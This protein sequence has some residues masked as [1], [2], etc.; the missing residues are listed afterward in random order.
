MCYIY[1]LMHHKCTYIHSRGS[2][3]PS[4]WT[5]QTSS[6]SKE[7]IR[8]W[9]DSVSFHGTCVSIEVISQQRDCPESSATKV[10]LVWPLVRVA[11]H[12]TVQVRTPRAG[13]AA[14]FTLECLLHPYSEKD[15]HC[16]EAEPAACH[17]HTPLPDFHF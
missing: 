17:T 8:K 16:S 15:V 2:I 10:A 3:K 13:V 14:Q 9:H 5:S 7:P 1:I 12:V 6:H 11:F 4:I